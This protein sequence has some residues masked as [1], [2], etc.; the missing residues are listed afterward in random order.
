M[1]QLPVCIIIVL[2]CC[3]H[4]YSFIELL[5]INKINKPK[6]HLKK[7]NWKGFLSLFS[8]IFYFHIIWYH[9]HYWSCTWTWN[10]ILMDK[11]FC[12]NENDWVW[13]SRSS[14]FRTNFQLTLFS[15][16]MNNIILSPYVPDWYNYPKWV[17]FK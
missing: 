12:W 4:I 1:F 3:A 2:C 8:S 15:I 11:Y 13:V 6:L 16:L 9:D 5:K 14:G 7:L 10:S 17:Q